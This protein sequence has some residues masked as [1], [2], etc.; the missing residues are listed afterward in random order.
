MAP[1][2][3]EED[4]SDD[5]IPLATRVKKETGTPKGKTHGIELQ[6]SR[7]RGGTE[8]FL[9]R[10]SFL[11]G[12]AKFKTFCLTGGPSFPS[13]PPYHSQEGGAREK[14]IRPGEEKRRRGQEAQGGAQG[15]RPPGAEA[16]PPRGGRV[17]A[18][19]LHI[20]AQAEARE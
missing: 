18:Q 16:R 2:I 7:A 12:T 20:A 11:T 19:I 5:E 17:T 10:I 14:Q 15:V 9:P 4:D 8:F 1:K 3:I 13:S 6:S